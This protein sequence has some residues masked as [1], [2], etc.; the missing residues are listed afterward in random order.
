MH[1]LIHNSLS[2]LSSERGVQGQIVCHCSTEDFSVSA[3]NEH[4]LSLYCRT[5]V[6][7]RC[8]AISVQFIKIF[9]SEKKI[10]VPLMPLAVEGDSSTAREETFFL[11]SGSNSSA[12]D[13]L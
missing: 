11:Q 4:F 2:V 9:S 3:V 13:F 5:P 7:C 6:L 10:E 8:F 1:S 12:E